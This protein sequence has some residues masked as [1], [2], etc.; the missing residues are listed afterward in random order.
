M[1]TFLGIEIGG[2]KLQMVVG[3]EQAQILERFRFEVE[4][5]DGAQGIKKKIKD[6]LRK[7][8]LHE[9][10]AIGIGFGGP[11]DYA[12]GKVFT[13]HQIKGWGN[14]SIRD[15]LE[16]LA[17]I[18]VW[19]ENDGNVAALGESLFGG[20]KNF[21][22]VFYVTLGSGVGAGLVIDKEI[23]HGRIH[24]EAEFG[25]IRL[26]KNGRTVE[27]SCSGWAVDL[28]IRSFVS[29]HPGSLLGQLTL[30]YSRGEAR[31]L[32]KAVSSNDQDSI[33]ILEETA[34]D[35][36]FG[37]SHAVHLLNPETIILG[38]GLSLIGEPFRKLVEQK[39]PNYIMEV[40]HPAPVIQLS[41][42]KEDAV[43]IGALALAIHKLNAA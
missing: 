39:L 43:P 38:G 18:P 17:G 12:N 10:A 20:G 15:W 4:Q 29:L 35:L 11:V 26:D 16:E 42:L 27:S 21:G 1:R 25:H 41:S 7:A 24:G 8:R 28:K 37:L 5:D 13:S 23:Y 40:F 22:Q 33:S 32:G 34:D 36:A 2:T 6:T 30:P 3:N 14:F 9:V 31:V 19:L